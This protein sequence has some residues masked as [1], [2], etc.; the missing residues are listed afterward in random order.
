MCGRFAQYRYALDYL[1]AL[2]AGV[3]DV[4]TGLEPRALGR[5]N[6][7]PGTRVPLLHLQADGLHLDPVRWG[8]QP[9]W[10]RQ[11]KRPP[12]INARVETAATSR[13]FRGLWRNGRALVVADG[14]YEWKKDPA[15]P[16]RKQPYF[17][18]TRS[19]EP[20]FFAA[21][22]HFRPADQAPQEEDGFVIVTAAAD[23]GMVD[24]HDRRPLVLPPPIAREWLDPALDDARASEI[25][26]VEGMPVAAFD[27][28]PVGQAVGSVK[29]EGPALLT[30]VDDPLV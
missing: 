2:G 3:S 8:Y 7:A 10:A 1:G 22:G 29:N 21:I 14:W 19:G 16:K 17:I 30:R 18:T 20:L 26:Q 12:V 24:I 6:V 15:D 25:G 27:W 9:A 11:A 5:Y 23:A 28:Y 4:R 13:M